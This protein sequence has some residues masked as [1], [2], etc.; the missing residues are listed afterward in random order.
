MGAAVAARCLNTDAEST[1]PR[2]GFEPPQTESESVVLPLH[3][4]GSVG[5]NLPDRPGSVKQPEPAGHRPKR[6]IHWQN[7]LGF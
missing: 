5:S 3:Q 2:E 4:R 6:L 1:I 7:R